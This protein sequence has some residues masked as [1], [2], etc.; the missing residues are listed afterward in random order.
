LNDRRDPCNNNNNKRHKR[1]KLAL[2]ECGIRRRKKEVRLVA[3]SDII[4]ILRHRHTHARVRLKSA[5]KT[6]EKV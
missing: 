1:K 3:I 5:S 6:Q 4:F 2:N